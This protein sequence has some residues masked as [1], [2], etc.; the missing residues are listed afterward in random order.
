[1]LWNA[2]NGSVPIGSTEMSYV[3]FG[4]GEKK[5]IVLPGLSDG[6]MTV[7][8]KTLLLAAPFRP[9]FEIDETP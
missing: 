2:K 3:S 4:H 5:L 9:F 8:G 6:L 7:R 1:M